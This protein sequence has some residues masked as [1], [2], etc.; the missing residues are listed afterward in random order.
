MSIR[1][2]ILLAFAASLAAMLLQAAISGWFVREL[3]VTVERLVLAESARKHSFSAS[4]LLDTLQDP[5][6][7]LEQGQH[8]DDTLQTLSVY[9]TS[10][11]E[12]LIKLLNA[13]REIKLDDARLA[14]F[15]A[16]VSL[17]KDQFRE[18][19]RLRSDG[20]P[21]RALEVSIYLGDAIANLREQLSVMAVEYGKALDAAV[22]REKEIHNRPVVASLSLVAVSALVII[23]FALLLSRHLGNNMAALI[24]RVEAIARGDLSVAGHE[25]MGSDELA[26]LARRMDDMSDRL[27]VTLIDIRNASQSIAGTAAEISQG[28]ADLSR[29]TESQAMLLM[30]TTERIEELNQA[31]IQNAGNADSANRLAG[32]ARQKAERGGDAAREVVEAMRE[33]DLAS[34]RIGQIIGVI[35][36]IAFQTN[37][38]ALNAAIETARAG[39]HGRGFAVVASEV[40]TLAQRSASAA[41]EIKSLVQDTTGK[42]GQGSHLARESGEVLDDIVQAVKKLD[43]LIGEIARSSTHQAEGIG[44]VTGA[45][46]ELESVTQQ[47]AALVEQAA[48]AS[49]S[50]RDQTQHLDT[51]VAFFKLRTPDASPYQPN[52][53]EPV[54]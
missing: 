29:R 25:G 51:Q 9:Y 50:F 21:D 18:V 40:R 27:S 47:N 12:S 34:R 37:L 1:N 42:V 17:L 31:V 54:R 45:I 10:L 30:R 19:E 44:K 2:K 24:R 22:A 16:A 41:R 20:S 38:L 11:A 52:A 46:G 13:N 26:G 6:G 4:E 15:S 5:I 8:D 43:D 49:E 28:N 3:Q 53:L 48:A 32:T 33:I 36:E 23:G 14:Q 35:D 39:E 7:R